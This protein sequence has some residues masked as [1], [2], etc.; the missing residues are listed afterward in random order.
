MKNTLKY[1]KKSSSPYMLVADF[2]RDVLYLKDNPEATSDT[3]WCYIPADPDYETAYGKGRDEE[4]MILGDGT[5]G[6]A[7]ATEKHPWFGDK[8]CSECGDPV[9]TPKH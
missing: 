9:D 2:E 5:D 7:S 3:Y 4:V 1:L 6:F 8:F